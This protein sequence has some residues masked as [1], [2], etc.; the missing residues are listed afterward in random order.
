M[1]GFQDP[2]RFSR[3]FFYVMT[4]RNQVSFKMLSAEMEKQETKGRT[5]LIALFDAGTFVEMGA[6][7]RRR[8]GEAY[9]AVLCGYGSI[10][11]KLSFAFVQDSDRTAGAL[12]DI[13]A[14][15]IERLYEEAIRVGAPVIA[16]FDSAGAVVADGASALSACGR[17]M[18]C[19]SA[20]SGVIPQLAIVNG[21]CAGLSAVI[22]SMFDVTVTVKTDAML[23]FHAVK[24]GEREDYAEARGLAAI[25]VEHIMAANNTVRQLVTL[26]P[27][28]NRDVADIEP[29]D[30]PDRPVAVDELTG[31]ALVNALA[32]N[33][34]A[35]TLY[36][37]Y[38]PE[39]VTAIMAIGGRTCGV[40]ASDASHGGGKLTPKGAR[41]AARLI[42]FCDS[43]SIPVITLVDSLGVDTSAPREPAPAFGKLAK[44]YVT[45]TTAKISVVMGNAIGAAFT[46]LGSRALGA[47]LALAV[48]EAVISVLPTEAAVAFLWNDRIT[49]DK[50]RSAVEAEWESEMAS[51]IR[52]A[53]CGDIDDIVPSVELRA[54]LASALY[55]L[56]E[57]ADSTPDRKHGV[58]TL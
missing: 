25:T 32:D 17:V 49:A 9:D 23:S 38:A 8:E 24:G 40:I 21:V 22:A 16:V 39:M 36:D 3:E 43:F 5:G 12:D 50:P 37:A 58:P 6:Y 33:G 2:A 42:S 47:D 53:E 29:T 30:A 45:A 13:G 51:P 28:N 57:K 52:A 41:K 56:A 35:I 1:G 19:V 7:V 46:L 26:L 27:R 34:V 11:G 10:G 55:M 54:R 18:N 4:E 14:S 31:L 44:A 20:A 15:K 48:P